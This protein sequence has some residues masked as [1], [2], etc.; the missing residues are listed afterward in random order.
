[1][2]SAYRREWNEALSARQQR[3][4]VTATSAILNGSPWLVRLGRLGYVAKGTVYIV[5]GFLATKAAIGAGGRTTDT[6]GAIQAIGEAPFGKVA[7]WIILI[8]LFGYAAWRLTSAVTDAER[9]GD[10]PSSIA[11][12][13]GEAVRGLAYGSLG[14]W[15]LKYVRS[16][17]A[18]SGDPAQS[19]TGRVLDWPAGRWIVIAVG[20]GIV[21][22]A[23]YQIYRAWS[24]KFLKRFDLSACGSGTRKWVTRTGRFGIAARGIVFGMIG[25][26]VVGAGWAYDP[27]RVGGI[28]QS[29]DALAAQPAGR[30]IFGAVA[31]G[32]I[33]FGLFELATARYRVMRAS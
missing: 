26:L 5:I 11:L 17:R 23:F 12:R 1:M 21:G 20:L 33:A 15:T 30:Y 18:E 25:L 29:L 16:D 19:L 10:E 8:G 27:S 22:Y 31:V 13:I 3:N 9:R 14:Y 6:R 24:G 7:L 32:L 28:R 4:C 2:L